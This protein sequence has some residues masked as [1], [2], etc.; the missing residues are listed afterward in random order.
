[1]KYQNFLSWT[2][3]QNWCNLKSQKLFKLHTVCTCS[4]RSFFSCTRATIFSSS[5]LLLASDLASSSFVL[6]N[7]S[8]IMASSFSVPTLIKRGFNLKYSFIQGHCLTLMNARMLYWMQRMDSLKPRWSISTVNKAHLWAARAGRGHTPVV[9]HFFQLKSVEVSPAQSLDPCDQLSQTIIS[10]LF[11]DTQQTCLEEHLQPK[12]RQHSLLRLHFKAMHVSLSC[13]KVKH[14][15]SCAQICTEYDLSQWKTA[16]FHTP[17][18]Y[19]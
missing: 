19:Q 10:H 16:T 15:P 8:F 2:L 14:L 12:N 7:S 13:G 3:R 11:Q 5:L 17:S 9:K 6:S 4:C 1:M 18:C